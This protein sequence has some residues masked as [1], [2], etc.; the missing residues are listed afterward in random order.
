M[1]SDT[2]AAQTRALV[3]ARQT[4]FGLSQIC[5]TSHANRLTIGGGV[6]PSKN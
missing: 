3:A 4:W 5:L 6:R 2:Y 1:R